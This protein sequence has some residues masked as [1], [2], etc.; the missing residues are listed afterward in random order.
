M[1][2]IPSWEANRLSDKKFSRFYGTRRFVTIFT[3]PYSEPDQSSPCPP[4]HFLKI[5]LNIINLSMPGSSKWSLYLR[6]PHQN[7]YSLHLSPTL[8]TWPVHLILYL[9]NGIIFGEEYKSLSST[10][11]SLLHSS[12]TSSVLG[13]HIFV[14]TLFTNTTAT[15][16]PQRERPSFTPIQNNR[17][18][19]SSV[20]L[21]L[22]IF[23]YN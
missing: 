20:S 9:I 5:H 12:T 21:N 1:E 16:L 8:A 23:G 3:S 2:H 22:Y 4:S 17:Q 10:L 6:F 19:Y 18:N 14:G 15:F 7:M 11:C 13:P